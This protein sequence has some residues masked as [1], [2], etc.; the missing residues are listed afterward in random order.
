MSLIVL[1]E[2][3]L[4]EKEC[5]HCQLVK[6]YVVGTVKDRNL[7]IKYAGWYLK[8]NSVTGLKLCSFLYLYGLQRN[9][10]INPFLASLN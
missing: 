6:F 9:V 7:D 10:L 3:T 5:R 8:T 4:Y 2:P 1:S